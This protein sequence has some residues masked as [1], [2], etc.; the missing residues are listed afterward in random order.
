L[1][2]KERKR[3]EKRGERRDRM[4]WGGLAVSDLV[5]C[6]FAFL[7]NVETADEEVPFTLKPCWSCD[8]YF[9]GWR[10]RE[11]LDACYAYET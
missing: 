5:F 7:F 1:W 4:G 6:D 2:V 10:W 11:T 9:S 8:T 3:R